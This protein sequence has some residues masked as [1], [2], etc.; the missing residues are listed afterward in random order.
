MPTLTL[1]NSSAFQKK[2]FTLNYNKIKAAE[3]ANHEEK[4]LVLNDV[5]KTWMKEGEYTSTYILVQ[6]FIATLVV[7]SDGSG[8]MP[9]QAGLTSTNELENWSL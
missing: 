2:S 9:G 3:S 8:P 1:N 5:C 6:S 7:R 4:I